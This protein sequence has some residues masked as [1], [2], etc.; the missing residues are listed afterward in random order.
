MFV[1]DLR[2]HTKTWRRCG[3]AK[4]KLFAINGVRLQI[5]VSYG[6]TISNKLNAAHQQSEL[7]RVGLIIMISKQF[8][9]IY[10]FGNTY[11]NVSVCQ[12]I[13]LFTCTK[14]TYTQLVIQHY[15]EMCLQWCTWWCIFSKHVH[16]SCQAGIY[17][18]TC[19][20]SIK[21]THGH[22]EIYRDNHPR[23]KYEFGVKWSN[24]WP[25]DP[26]YER[27]HQQSISNHIT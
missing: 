17:T 2:V 27:K 9:H 1:I 6:K 3:F 15:N 7:S 18:H 26:G 4:G 14:N 22:T 12:H 20:C 11:T 25:T 5:I 21:P 19:I 24:S 8:L 13:F 16:F 23:D 10:G